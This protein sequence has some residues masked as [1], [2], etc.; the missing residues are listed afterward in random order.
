LTHT[1]STVHSAPPDKM[2]QLE[3]R[4]PASI[5]R[6]PLGLVW[7]DCPYPV[8]AAGLKSAL[9]RRAR[10]HLGSSPPQD[11]VPSSAIFDAGGVEGLSEGIKRIQ[12]VN[13][14]ISV[15]VFSLHVDLPLARAALRFGARGFIH[16]GMEPE[17]I[18]RAV[19]VAARGEIVA[20]RKFLE[21][22]IANEGPADLDAVTP[23]QRDVLGLVAEGLS[24]AEIAKRLF[25]SESTVKQHL[26]AAY[27][28]LGVKDRREA[29]KFVNGY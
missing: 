29:A 8:V 11:D 13:P 25:L 22:L 20:P 18:A 19:E 5:E 28:I 1:A 3:A 12:E 15:L 17:Q 9:E 2:K 6:K 4:Q 23:R 21:F 10:V 26:R 27:K 24:N 16:A 14:A 7:I